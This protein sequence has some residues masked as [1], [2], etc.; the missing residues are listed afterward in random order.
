MKQSIIKSG[1]LLRKS[2]PKTNGVTTGNQLASLWTS[3]EIANAH[4]FLPEVNDKGIK[5]YGC[6]IIENKWGYG[7]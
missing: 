3:K 2:L 6:Q 7:G 1:K 4:T 5:E